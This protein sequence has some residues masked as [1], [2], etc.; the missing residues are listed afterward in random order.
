MPLRRKG[1]WVVLHWKVYTDVA[2]GL[3]LPMIWIDLQQRNSYAESLI[4]TTKCL[5]VP[6]SSG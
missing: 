4:V 3:K 2:V 6:E 1:V 5:I